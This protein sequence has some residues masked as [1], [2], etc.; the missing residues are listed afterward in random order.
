MAHLHVRQTSHDGRGCSEQK[1]DCDDAGETAHVAFSIRLFSLE[2]STARVSAAFAEGDAV[3]T[4][5]G[6]PY[7]LDAVTCSPVYVLKGHF[8]AFCESYFL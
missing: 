5:G 3:T 8:D 2:I 4:K 1:K 7:N 6:G